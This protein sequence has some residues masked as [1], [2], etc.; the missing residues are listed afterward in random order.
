MRNRQMIVHWLMAH[1]TAI[2]VRWR[3][4]KTYYVMTDPK[5]FE[6]DFFFEQPT[7]LTSATHRAAWTK[8]EVRMGESLRCGRG[9]TDN[10]RPDGCHLVC[11]RQ[12]EAQGN[13]LCRRR[14]CYGGN[15]D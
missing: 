10:R 7:A 13:D 3:D 2:D 12:A 6:L 9:R 1:T 15:G 4:G 11:A 8:V 14:F 5:A